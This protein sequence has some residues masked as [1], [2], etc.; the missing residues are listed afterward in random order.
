[1]GLKKYAYLVIPV[2]AAA[3]F[4]LAKYIATK[5]GRYQLDV[6]LLRL[7]VIGLLLRKIYVCRFAHT[8]ALLLSS[9]VAVLQSLDIVK[10]VI[11]NEVMSRVIS[12]TRES[13]ESGERISAALRVSGSFL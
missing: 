11:G 6:L 10:E 3:V 7:P 4:F 13:T 1:M 9:G 2:S 5:K 8:L 12:K